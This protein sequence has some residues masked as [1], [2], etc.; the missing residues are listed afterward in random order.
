MSRREPVEIYLTV[1]R[2]STDPDSLSLR[3]WSASKG[4]LSAD[5]LKHKL[6]VAGYQ[7]GDEVRLSIMHKE[8]P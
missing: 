4:R 1:V 7:E 6:V 2:S 5:E 8:R 3:A